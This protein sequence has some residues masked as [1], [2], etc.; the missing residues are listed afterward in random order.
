MSRWRYVTILTLGMFVFILGL[1]GCQAMSRKYDDWINHTRV[2]YNYE[3][4]STHVAV[5]SVTPWE[6]VVSALQPKY[7]MTPDKALKQAIPT[8]MQLQQTIKDTLSLI[9]KGTPGGSGP[10]PTESQGSQKPEGTSTKQKDAAAPPA[11]TGSEKKQ[12]DAAADKLALESLGRDPMLSYLAATSLFQEVNLLN[13]FLH[14]AAVR[15]K[16]RAYVVR[17]QVS[18]M[19]R[20]RNMPYDTY[21]NISFLLTT[22]GNY[23]KEMKK[24]QEEEQ[25]K[26]DGKAYLPTLGKEKEEQNEKKK[27]PYLPVMGPIV[28]PLLVTDDIE[29]M[30]YSRTLQ[31]IHTFGLGL[32]GV[33]QGIGVQADFKKASD[34]LQK[35]TGENFNSLLSVARVSDNTL[36]VRL[37]AMQQGNSVYAIVPRTHNI[38]VLLLVPEKQWDSEKKIYRDWTLWEWGDQEEKKIY[39]DTWTSFVDSV[40]GKVLKNTEGNAAL[41]KEMRG[42]SRDYGFPS[43]DIGI[44]NW[45]FSTNRQ[46]KFIERYYEARNPS[47]KGASIGQPGDGSTNKPAPD[48]GKKPG[49]REDVI[50]DVRATDF[51]LAVGDLGVGSVSGYA[52]FVLPKRTSCMPEQT[53]LLVD[54]G[55]TTKAF[56]NGPCTYSTTSIKEA[57]LKICAAG[58]EDIFPAK[59]FSFSNTWCEEVTLTF[60]SLKYMN[61]VVDRDGKHEGDTKDSGKTN[62]K[63]RVHFKLNSDDKSECLGGPFDFETRYVLKPEKS[64]PSGGK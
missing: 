4:G 43:A 62:T 49:D 13:R 2:S 11:K 21:V 60:P 57:Y 38:S 44:M 41:N 28:V 45:Y 40:S 27:K 17:L 22:Y 55:T 39:I 33:A 6:E 18:V 64:S 24:Q 23:R 1:F 3:V 56:L 61:Y 26:K 12:K 7:D 48:S 63:V 36:R 9:L 31:D 52:S 34:S 20:A 35:V 58:K 53:V 8:T 32:L 51:Y 59:N 19:P 16:Y 46:D 54:N 47:S 14:D 50:E 37:G 42:I 30:A 10:T 29:A 15:D 5:L 25:N